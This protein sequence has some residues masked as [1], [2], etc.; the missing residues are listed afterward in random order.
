M[1]RCRAAVKRPTRTRPDR[2][3]STRPN[4]DGPLRRLPDGL[5]F[6]QRRSFEFRPDGTARVEAGSATP[7]WAVIPA[8]GL[9]LSVTNG[10]ATRSITVNGMGRVQIVL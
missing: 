5:A 8:G 9:V 6:S 4:H 7:E 1:S 3:P 2:D 10:T